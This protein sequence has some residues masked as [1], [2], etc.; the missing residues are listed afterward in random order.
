[1]RKPAAESSPAPAKGAAPA[2]AAPQPKQDDDADLASLAA[3]ALEL[4][5]E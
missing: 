5:E 1:V 3:E 4:D 2:K